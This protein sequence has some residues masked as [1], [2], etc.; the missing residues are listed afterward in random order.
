MNDKNRECPGNR[1]IWT[2][3]PETALQLLPDLPI[4]GSFHKKFVRRSYRLGLTNFLLQ[5]AQ[6]CQTC[7]EFSAVS[8]C[9]V[10]NHTSESQ[11]ILSL[12]LCKRW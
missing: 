1:N 10:H 4:F 8:G 11:P 9:D 5:A 2:S 12:F 3:H 6:D 7:G